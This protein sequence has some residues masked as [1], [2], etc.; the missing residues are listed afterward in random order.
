MVIG[1]SDGGQNSGDS[2]YQNTGG[3]NNN[4]LTLV[5]Q[6]NQS[7]R[8]AIGAKVIVRTGIILQVG[9]VNSGNGKNEESLPLEFG[10]GAATS[11][12]VIVEWPS[13]KQQGAPGLTANRKVTIV[14]Q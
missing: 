8:S 14:E 1:D 9:V 4:W 10:L 13:G 3:G 6:G 12:D 2:V 7:N 11:A 5:L